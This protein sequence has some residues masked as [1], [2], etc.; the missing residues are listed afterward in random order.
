MKF[1]FLVIFE[2]ILWMGLK[3]I[4]ETMCGLSPFDAAMTIIV[5]SIGIILGR[6][7]EFDDTPRQ[8]QK[9]LMRSKTP[10][11]EITGR[12][13]AINSETVEGSTVYYLTIDGSEETLWTTSL[14]GIAVA[15]ASVGDEVNITYLKPEN[16]IA[17]YA[18]RQ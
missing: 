10:P 3:W 1:V 16:V 7:M 18:M 14:I 6:I 9:R 12:I 17:S 5:P 8:V 11:T 4:L 15:S 2:S 13:S